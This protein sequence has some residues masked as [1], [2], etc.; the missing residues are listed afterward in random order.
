MCGPLQASKLAADGD[1][2]PDTI[3]RHCC[4]R[5]SRSLRE[6]SG[7]LL[8]RVH[9]HAGWVPKGPI[10]A[11]IG[12]ADRRV[13]NEIASRK[14]VHYQPRGRMCHRDE[15]AS[16]SV[17]RRSRIGT[18]GPRRHVLFYCDTSSSRKTRRDEG[19]FTIS[20]NRT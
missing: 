12:E 9:V 5:E 15:T 16:A 20:S 7:Y 11:G 6:R 19:I 17:P 4:P 8:L 13:C 10:H 3:K 1:H 2:R 14:L 18:V